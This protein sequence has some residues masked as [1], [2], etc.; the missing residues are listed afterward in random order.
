M[1][2]W[3]GVESV[4]GIGLAIDS[5]S[6]SSLL[7]CFLSISACLVSLPPLALLLRLG[8]G[9]DGA[10]AGEPVLLASFAFLVFLIT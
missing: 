10:V 3:V 4:L 6:S 5:S 9:V 8:G 2:I 7:F 1:V